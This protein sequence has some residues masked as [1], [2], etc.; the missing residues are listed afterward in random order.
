M[1]I[2]QSKI[3]DHLGKLQLFNEKA[4][5]LERSDFLRQFLVDGTSVKISFGQ[6]EPVTVTTKLPTEGA[7]DAFMNNY[8]F[9]CQNNEGS[10]FQNIQ[11]VYDRL[12]IS[13]EIKNQFNNLRRNLNQY[14]D[15][16][17]EVNITINDRQLTKREL[18]DTL[19]YGLIVHSNVEKRGTINYWK[20]DS[21]LF[22]IISQEFSAIL[23][24]L[25][26]YIQIVRNLN[27][28]IINDLNSS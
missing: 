14:L 20:K 22:S 19:M 9:F 17:T 11:N 18:L 2:D 3:R 23:L 12:P 15:T 25:L 1:K 27:R 4:Q 8:R 21:I 24:D 6:N 13:K 26:R 16:P 10:S 5:K 28:D 7:I